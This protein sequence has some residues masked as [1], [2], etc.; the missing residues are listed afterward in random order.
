MQEHETAWIDGAEQCGKRLAA[1]QVLGRVPLERDE[2]LF[3]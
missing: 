2:R 1:D 3:V